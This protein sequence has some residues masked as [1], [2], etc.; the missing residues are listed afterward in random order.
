MAGEN[1]FPLE[2]KKCP[3]C[4]STETVAELAVQEAEKTK[5]VKRE[6]PFASL[7]KAA[8]PLADP[9][10]TAKLTLPMVICHYDVCAGCG[11]RYCT[12]AE[13]ID[14]PITFTVKGQPPPGMDF[15]GGKPG[16]G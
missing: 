14:A 3:N 6:G 1:N 8:I 7:E 13:I 10:K 5:G 2:F 11:L 12:K 4:G 16:P 15:K 9:G